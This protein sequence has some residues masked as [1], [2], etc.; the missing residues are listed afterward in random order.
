MGQL[1]VNYCA[2]TASSQTAGGASAIAGLALTV[3]FLLSGTLLTRIRRN[4]SSLKHL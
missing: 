4:F 3:A 2:A 1:C